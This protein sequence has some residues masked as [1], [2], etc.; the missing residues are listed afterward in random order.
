MIIILF[1]LHNHAFL[2][3]RNLLKNN[4]QNRLVLISNLEIEPIEKDRETLIQKIKTKFENLFYK[5]IANNIQ[6]YI[7]P[8]NVVFMGN[9]IKNEEKINIKDAEINAFQR[10]QDLFFEDLNKKKAIF[11]PGKNELFPDQLKQNLEENLEEHLEENYEKEMQEYLTEIFKS[12][13]NDFNIRMTKDD[14]E[15][16]FLNSLF[17]DEEE[18]NRNLESLN[19]LKSFE[20]QAK[21]R[22]LFSHLPLSKTIGACLD[23][24]NSTLEEKKTVSKVSSFVVLS[25]ILP[26]FIFSGNS[27]KYCEFRFGKETLEFVVPSLRKTGQYLI[28]EYLGSENSLGY[29]YNILSCGSIS[30]KF[31]ISFWISSII[32]FVYVIYSFFTGIHFSEVWK[33]FQKKKRDSQKRKEK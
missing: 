28:F 33:E 12:N 17:L 25:S 29:D 2:C 22:I 6:K 24:N 31:F 14:H 30:F 19:F 23:G 26:R 15:L 18:T 20:S 10:F 13:F 3:Q 4:Q 16:I 7:K 5:Q 8:N 21:A 32:W 11:I 27:E 1:G 9:M